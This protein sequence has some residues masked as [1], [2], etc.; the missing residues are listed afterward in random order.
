MALRIS[1][2]LYGSGP[3]AACRRERTPSPQGRGVRKGREDESEGLSELLVRISV[4]ALGGAGAGGHVGGGGHGHGVGARG[5][6]SAGGDARPGA[7]RRPRCPE[8]RPGR[9]RVVSGGAMGG[10]VPGVADG[11]LHLAPLRAGAVAVPVG[12]QVVLDVVPLPALV[13]RGGLRA[14]PVGRTEVLI[15]APAGVRTAGVVV[16]PVAVLVVVPAVGRPV[17]GVLD[18]VLRLVPGEL[19]IALGLVPAALQSVL[20]LLPAPLAPV[21]PAGL[22]A[23]AVGRR[24]ILVPLVLRVRTGLVTLAPIGLFLGV[25]AVAVVDPVPGVVGRRLGGVPVQVGGSSLPLAPIAL[26]IALGVVPVAV[27]VAGA[28]LP[29]IAVGRAQILVV[30][31]LGIGP[32]LVGATPEGILLGRIDRLGEPLAGEAAGQSAHGR[33]DDGADRASHRSADHRADRAAGRRADSGS[34]RV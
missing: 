33:A 31:A 21:Q 24:E 29:A 7:E 15:L 34:H 13:V 30:V 11:V 4:R 3:G 10:A 18:R 9:R 26:E 8:S 2:S 27:G 28:G 12:L 20:V 22:P 25:V 16:P 19:G 23:V 14:V 5:I 32:V 1:R 17:P 6:G